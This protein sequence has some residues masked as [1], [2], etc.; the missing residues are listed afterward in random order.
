VSKW[1][2][3]LLAYGQDFEREMMDLNVNMP[4][5]KA[6][7]K[8]WEILAKHFEPVQTGLKEELLKAYWPDKFK[9]A[10]LFI[11]PSCVMPNATG[12]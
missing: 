9:G 7:D 4:I 3:T 11:D 12:T 1:D 6:L 8:C 2:E 5:E 10:P